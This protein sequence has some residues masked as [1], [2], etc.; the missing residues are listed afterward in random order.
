VRYEKSGTGAPGETTRVRIGFL[1]SNVARIAARQAEG[2]SFP[3]TAKM[4]RM[5]FA[6]GFMIFKSQINV[7]KREIVAPV[8]RKNHARIA[9]FVQERV[10]AAWAGKDPKS[11]AP[12][13]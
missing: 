5:I 11:I 13:F 10:N 6:A 12:P 8:F 4:R 7:P 3:V 1:T 9:R 2:F